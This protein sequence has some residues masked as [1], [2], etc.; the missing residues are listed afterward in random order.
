MDFSTGALSDG[1]TIFI[2]FIPVMILHETFIRFEARSKFSMTFPLYCRKIKFPF[3]SFSWIST[4]IFWIAD[5]AQCFTNNSLVEGRQFLQ[6]YFCFLETFMKTYPY[7]AYVK[8]L[9]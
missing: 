5:F 3:G 1:K 9:P 7:N 6:D 8:F 2:F 4:W